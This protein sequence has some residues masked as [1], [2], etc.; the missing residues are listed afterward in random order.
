MYV[1]IRGAY[2]PENGYIDFDSIGSTN[3]EAVL[4]HTNDPTCCAK[5][6][7]NPGDWF[8]PNGS[9]VESYT[10]N[11]ERSHF[12]FARNRGIDPPVV[13]LYMYHAQRFSPMVA[14]ER[15]RFHCEI[16]DVAGNLQQLHVNIRKLAQT[17]IALLKLF[18]YTC[19][20][21]WQCICVY[22]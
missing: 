1:T 14:Q 15:G 20:G 12:F 3:V 18:F 4:C 6:Q 11:I 16:R 9:V 22:T 21:Y 19:S 8:F 5:G 10:N 2:V 13:R 7:D 17:A